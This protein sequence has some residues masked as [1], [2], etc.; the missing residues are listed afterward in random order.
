MGGDTRR[1]KIIQIALWE[2]DRRQAEHF[3]S[4]SAT[5]AEKSHLEIMRATKE[6]GLATWALVF[7]AAAQLVRDDP[8]RVVIVTVIAFA[9]L[10]LRL[11]QARV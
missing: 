4:R 2:I 8:M 1:N 9:Y 7:L 3:Q 10:V 11:L 5:A 6:I